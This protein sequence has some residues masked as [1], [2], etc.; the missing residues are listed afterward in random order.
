MVFMKLFL[1]QDKSSYNMSVIAIYILILFV[2]FLI[3]V[4]ISSKLN[5]YNSRG[6][7]NIQTK[8]NTTN[9]IQMQ[10]LNES[11]ATI[12]DIRGAEDEQ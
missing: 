3:C 6:N 5:I 10:V 1:G 11:A 9:D 8:I 12:E 7:K 4:I 2:A